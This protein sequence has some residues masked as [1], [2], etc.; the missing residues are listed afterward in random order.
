M[1]AKM[2]INEVIREIKGYVSEPSN[3]ITLVEEH[4]EWKSTGILR[5]GK[6]RKLCI[7]YNAYLGESTLTAI[8]GMLVDAALKKLLD[9][10]NKTTKEI[11][12]LKKKLGIYDKLDAEIED[13]ERL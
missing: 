9:I 3:I 8:E 6:M 11:V 1:N 2:G 10:H 13:L 4:V 12:E 5:N 7:K